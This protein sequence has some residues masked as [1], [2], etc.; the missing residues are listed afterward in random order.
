MGEQTIGTCGKCNGAVTVP[1]LWHG[2][3]PPTPSCSSCGA[4]PKN[5]HGPKIE[6]GEEKYG[7]GKGN[8]TLENV[9]LTES[10]LNV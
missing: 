2:I 8:P 9:L 5:P 6:M 7:Y 3:H 1:D 4:V 10:N